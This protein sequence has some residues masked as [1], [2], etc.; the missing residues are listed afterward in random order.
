MELDRELATQ[1]EYNLVG[2]VESY[3][4]SEVEGCSTA[5]PFNTIVKFTYTEMVVKF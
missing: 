5:C 3:V 2:S 4:K 1:M